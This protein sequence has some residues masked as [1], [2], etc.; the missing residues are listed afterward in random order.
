MKCTPQKAISSAS[1][2]AARRESSSESPT[3][4]AAA[5]ISRLVVVRQ[6]DCVTLGCER[7][8]L[9]C[10]LLDLHLAEVENRYGLFDRRDLSHLRPRS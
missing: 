7:A 9:P 6:D 10:Q 2:A 3:K 5:W 1:V 8:H 4:S